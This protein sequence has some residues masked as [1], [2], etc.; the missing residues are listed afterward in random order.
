MPTKKIKPGHSVRFTE[1]AI[2]TLGHIG[3]MLKKVGNDFLV[4]E[5]IDQ[6]RSGSNMP[7]A[8]LKMP[9]L[10]TGKDVFCTSLLEV[11]PST[12]L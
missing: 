10:K 4:L 3:L 6:P 5:V 9:H 7:L 2:K 8:V 11:V 1:R 12:I